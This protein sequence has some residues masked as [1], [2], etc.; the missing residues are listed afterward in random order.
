MKENGH[1]KSGKLRIGLAAIGGLFIASSA[2]GFMTNYD[3]GRVDFAGRVTDISCSVA[4]NGGH[5]AGSGNV[6]LAPVSLAEVHDRG[7]GAFMKPQSFT[8]ELSNCQLRHDGGAADKNEI[9][10][11]NVRWVDGFLVTAVANENAGYLANTL[12]DGAQNIFLALSTNDNNTLDKSNKI[13]PADPQQNRVPIVE[14]SVN[15]GVF[16]YYIGYVTPS[17]EKATSGPLTSWATWE[18]VYN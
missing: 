7:A 14:K 1:K 15:G 6:W 17:P 18:L 13:V 16:T 8:L 5:N 3:N 4:L 12:P 2:S 9:R 11:V 10:A